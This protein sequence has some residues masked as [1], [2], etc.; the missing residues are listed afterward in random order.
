MDTE[1]TRDFNERCTQCAAVSWGITD[2]GTYYCTSCLNVTERHKE[3]ESIVDFTPNTKIQAIN[4]GLKK[5]RKLE[6]GW[7]WYICEGFQYILYQQAE[8]LLSLGVCPKL[9]DEVL[10]NFWK[11]YLQKS[12]QAYCRRPIYSNDN[13]SVASDSYLSLSGLDSEPE[14]LSIHS[15]PFS[16]SE[17][18]SHSEVSDR[19]I[20]PNIKFT[21]SER[22]RKGEKLQNK[23]EDLR[24][25]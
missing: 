24:N 15:Y 10:H 19:L 25:I 4:R 14:L 2:E 16:E 5:K 8:A 9:K 17:A 11:R 3:V 13:K 12:K 6:K 18:E 21:H 7:E 22:N 23:G 20:L 1:E